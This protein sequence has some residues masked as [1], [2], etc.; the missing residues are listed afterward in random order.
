MNSMPTEDSAGVT[1]PSTVLRYKICNACGLKFTTREGYGG[2]A[3]E[4][5]GSNASQ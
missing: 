4:D 1:H 2:K 3:G 5:G